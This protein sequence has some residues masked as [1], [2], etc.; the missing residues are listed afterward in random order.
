M[1][2][3]FVGITSMCIIISL[4]TIFVYSYKGRIKTSETRIYTFLLII[5][6]IALLLEMFSHLG[7]ANAYKSHVIKQTF[8][9]GNKLYIIS[10]LIWFL[11]FNIY[12]FLITSK[13]KTESKEYKKY[14]VKVRAINL[15]LMIISGILILVSKLEIVYSSETS[16]FT[17]GFGVNYVLIPVGFTCFFIWLVKCLKNFKHLKQKKYLPILICI[18]LMIVIGIV[19]SYD[20]SYLI[21]VTCQTIVTMLMFHT[22]ENPDLKLLNEMEL[23]KDMAEKANRAK[24]DFLSSMS[25]EIRT[26]LNAI[27]GLSELNKDV[28]TLDEAKENSVDIINASKV[29]H[30]IVG[31]VLDMSK[32]E[33]G[34]VDITDKEYDA[35]EMF[36]N[37]IK[38]V[39]YKFE[40][41]GIKLNVKI[42]PDLPQ[43]LIG[44]KSNITKTIMNLLTNAVKYTSEGY[45]NLDINCIN[46]SDVSTLI[47]S[48][49]DTGRGIKPEQLDKLFVRFSRL[50]E[51]RNTTTEGTGLGLAITKHIL[52]L[53]GG[54]VTVQSVYGRG[55]KFTITLNQK[56]VNTFNYQNNDNNLELPS[57][58]SNN[59][60]N[61]QSESEE[62][63]SNFSGKKILII[64]DNVVNLKVATRLLQKFNCE[65]EEVSSGHEC[66]D[67]I[68]NGGKYDLLLMDEMMPNMSGTETMKKLKE[69]GYTIPI[70]V[71][72]A[73]V[74]A[75]SR[76]K[77]ISSGF[78]EYLG[79]PTSLKELERVLIKFLQ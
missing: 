18:L 19:Q 43:K 72:T 8:F 79:K 31:N 10:I 65:T 61:N 30:E 24:S 12:V 34:T 49:E 76:E 45:V 36:Q 5:N 38:L 25:H 39:E 21:I 71:L 68:N 16:A 37:V 55:S 14:H 33:S 29:L 46:K 60:T 27:M 32:I 63:I 28:E 67:K 51:D 26:P 78:N 11:I 64:D 17:T 47:I 77:F 48:V 75:N 44:D 54:K 40:E 70:V 50:E 22:I 74:E 53:M 62:N 4:I 13:Y 69:R 6:F 57:V 9:V 7:V 59:K 15:L 73:D 2:L 1:N 56:I 20:R 58:D 23:A 41:K 42:A 35:Y 66:I 52:E 3:F